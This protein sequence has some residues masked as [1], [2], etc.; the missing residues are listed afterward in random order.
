MA[1]R[2]HFFCHFLHRV[3]RGWCGG[4]NKESKGCRTGRSILE[5]KPKFHGYWSSCQFV[6]YFIVDN[7]KTIFPN[8]CKSNL[9]AKSYISVEQRQRIHSEV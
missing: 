1:P 8:M 2:A 3:S 5:N 9:F 4:V 6:E 7:K